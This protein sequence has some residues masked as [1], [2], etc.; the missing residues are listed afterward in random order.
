M[1][2]SDEA[3]DENELPFGIEFIEDRSIG[4]VNR[5]PLGLIVK[6][7]SSGSHK[8]EG[9]EVGHQIGADSG[10]AHRKFNAKFLVLKAQKNPY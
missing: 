1:V 8:S 9:S 7:R 2:G 6:H 10:H 4:C 5:N 3:V